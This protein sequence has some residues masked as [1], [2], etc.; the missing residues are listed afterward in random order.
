MAHLLMPHV[1]AMRYIHDVLLR[2]QRSFSIVSTPL[3]GYA[4]FD[5]RQE[6]FIAL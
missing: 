6:S 4:Q 5:M 2:R 1:I 3:N